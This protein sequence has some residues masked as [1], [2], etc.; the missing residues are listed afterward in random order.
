V[1]SPTV[2]PAAANLWLEDERMRRVAGSPPP[3]TA[4]QALDAYRLMLLIR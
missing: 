4:E 2:N 1:N 3:L